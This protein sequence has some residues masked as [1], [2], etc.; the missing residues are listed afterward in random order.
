MAKKIA[1]RK[2]NRETKITIV[3]TERGLWNLNRFK[4]FWEIK[5]H[6]EAVEKALA[7]YGIDI[8]EK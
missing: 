5:S 4:D 2:R 6:E 3:C 1:R 8:K 7:L